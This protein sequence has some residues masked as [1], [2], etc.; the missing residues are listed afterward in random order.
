MGVDGAA[1][2]LYLEYYAAKEVRIPPAL[3]HGVGEVVTEGTLLDRKAYER[4][5]IYQ[6]LLLPHDI[7]HI[8]AIWLQRTSRACQ[9]LVVE[10]GRRHGPFQQD[11]REKFSA[12][13]PHLIRV[14]RI[15]E[16]LASA[17]R[18]RDIRMDILDRLPFGVIFLDTTGAIVAASAF[19]ERMLQE[20]NG[21]RV[22]QSRLNAEFPD[23]DRLLQD[24]I[25]RSARPRGARST[26]GATLAVRRRPPT[27]PLS[28]AVVPIT[29]S[30][31]LTITPQPAALIIMTDPARAPAARAK[32]IQTALRL[33]DAESR[34]A[35]ALA[36][37]VSLRE[38]AD[39]LGKSFH[40]CKTQLKSI[41]AKT[42][43]RNHVELS[44]WLLLLAVADEVRG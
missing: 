6:D 26:P 18:E 37:G 17:R 31:V 32:V 3:A 36:A 7:P 20:G 24:A 9:A 11:A 10:A 19:G 29:P 8:M 44:K 25:F 33:T 12:L 15:R 1:N 4:S 5:E 38:A 13:V 16:V 30:P 23:D 40:T 39:S 43:C 42:G 41:Y 28:V 2:E 34:L 27:P 21:I 14:A 22:R 35:A